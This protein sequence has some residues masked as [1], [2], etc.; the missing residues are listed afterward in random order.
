LGLSGGK[1]GEELAEIEGW[2]T[3]EV[4][5]HTLSLEDLK[6]GQVDTSLENGSGEIRAFPGYKQPARTDVDERG[7][8]CA[9][10]GL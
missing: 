9:E 2:T 4:E 7:N 1:R 3:V 8:T 6:S 10:A 5:P